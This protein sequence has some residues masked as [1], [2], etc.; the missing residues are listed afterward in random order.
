MSES[1]KDVVGYEGRYEVSNLGRV[2]SV[3]R[4]CSSSQGVERT[5]PAKIL[6][7]TLW[8]PYPSVT[9]FMDGVRC[10]RKLAHLVLEAFVGPRLEGQEAC[11]NDGVYTN[12]SLDN[13]RY[14]TRAG[15]FADK[16][17]HGTHQRGERNGHRKL[18][19]IEI[20]AIRAA[21][22]TQQDIADVFGICQPH[23]SDIKNG[24]AWSHL[25]AP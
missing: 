4:T 9:L 22:G 11:H 20:R 7:G 1:W 24:K 6:T 14:D 16:V 23:V 8:G 3:R 15:N 21:K 2:R 12:S 25:D 18:T 10:R 13:L 5:V 17:R 19:E